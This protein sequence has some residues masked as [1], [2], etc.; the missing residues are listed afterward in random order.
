MGAELDGWPG[1]RWLKL[2]SENVRN[3]MKKRIDLAWRKG[4]DG[5]DPD[6]VDGYVSHNLLYIYSL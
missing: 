5:V 3:I 4:C 6:N 2:S 1:E